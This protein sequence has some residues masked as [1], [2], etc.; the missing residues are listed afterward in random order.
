MKTSKANCPTE[1]IVTKKIKE[2]LREKPYV[3]FFKVHVGMGMTMAGV[4]DIIACVNS[5]FMGIEIKRKSGKLTKLQVH[6][7]KEIAERGCGTVITAYGYEDFIEKF[8]KYY[9]L[10]VPVF[11][12]KKED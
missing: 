7:H 10:F 1:A 2:Y 4:P 8:E 6:R 5:H 11:L 9:A 12:R 3:W